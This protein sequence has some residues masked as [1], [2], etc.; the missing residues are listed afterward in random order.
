MLCCLR[1]DGASRDRGERKRSTSANL[2]KAFFS[3]Y[4]GYFLEFCSTFVLTFY[5]TTAIMKSE[6]E[7]MKMKRNITLKLSFHETN[8]LITALRKSMIECTNLADEHYENG[9]E[10]EGAF[11]EEEA[12]VYNALYEKLEEALE[13]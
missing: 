6:R 9:L 1:M 12:K 7:E 10:E 2:Y 13:C 5:N 4:I 8:A 3:F 11:Y